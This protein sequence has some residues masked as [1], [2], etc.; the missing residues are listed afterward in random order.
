MDHEIILTQIGQV[1]VI[2]WIGGASLGFPILIGLARWN[3]YKE[4]RACLEAAM[5]KG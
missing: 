1:L 4:A 3:D 2:I 5:G